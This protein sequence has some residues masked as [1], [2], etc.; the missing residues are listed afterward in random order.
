MFKQ[1]EA[2]RIKNEIQKEATNSSFKNQKTMSETNDGGPVL[3]DNTIKNLVGS[4]ENSTLY[5]VLSTGK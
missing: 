5:E 3:S 4:Q 1:S 2:L